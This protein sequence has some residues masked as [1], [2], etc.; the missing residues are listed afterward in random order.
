MTLAKK[1]KKLLPTLARKKN[2]LPVLARKKSLFPSLG[3]KGGFVDRK[4]LVRP[5]HFN[6]STELMNFGFTRRLPSS[7]IIETAKNFLIELATPGLERKDFKMETENS[8]LTVTVDKKEETDQ[9][10]RRK[11]FSFNS[12]SRS[13]TLPE[14]IHADRI[15]AHYEN[16]ILHL[17]I[18]K[19]APSTI[20]QKREIRI[21]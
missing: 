7:N 14:N 10:Y 3:K 18:P 2:L 19:K 20:K 1:T 8:I 16:G 9:R 13:F 15:E 21:T 11:E 6:Q 4:R 12:F 5:N 17:L